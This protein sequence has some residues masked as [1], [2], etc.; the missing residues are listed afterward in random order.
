MTAGLERINAVRE[1]MQGAEGRGPDRVADLKR[2]ISENIRPGMTVHTMVTHA[3]P[4]GLVNEL[5]RQFWGKK[6][7]FSLVTLGA[8]NHA[9]V[10]LSGG[11]LDRIVT[12]YC[13]DIYPSPGPHPL[14]QQAYLQ[15]WPTIENWSLIS[16]VSR[17]MAGALGLEALPVRSLS[18]TSM[19]EENRGNYA[20]VPSPFG[21]PPLGLVKALR[22]DITLLHG[23]V[24][25]RAGNT[26]LSPP[27]AEGLWGALGAREGV[28]VSVEKIVDTDFIRAHA[29]LPVLPAARVRAVVE[30]PF[31]AHPG[32]FFGRPIRGCASYAEDYD[33]IVDF[34]NRSRR[35][36]AMQQWLDTYVLGVAD[37]QEYLRRVGASRLG[38]L[39]GRAHAD[40]WEGELAS[41]ACDVPSGPA[42]PFEAMVAEAARQL[43]SRIRE[44]GHRSILAGQ[45]LSNLAAWLA[46]YRLR[47]QDV[48]IDLVAEAGFYGYLPRPGNPFLFNFA[49]LPRCTMLTDSLHTLG[50][51]ICGSF[52][53]AIGSL[54]AGQVDRQGHINSTL[55]PGVAYLVGSGGAAD[56]MA[57]AEEV[58]LCV[59]LRPL[60][61]VEKVPYVMA[62]GGRVVRVVSERGVLAKEAGQDELVLTQVTATSDSEI[63]ERVREMRELVGWELKV[64]PRLELTPRPEPLDIEAVRLFDPR[65][66][67]LER[68]QEKE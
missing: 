31:G 21:G 13:G 53:R 59:P 12:S 32:G 67:F 16:L 60:R 56:V 39:V 43:V 47:R 50:T 63:E 25:D 38:D 46:A 5:A 3:M 4:Y 40:A 57:A 65:R 2:A 9:V 22:P 15:G 45:G 51:E 52:A 44:K 20:E 64:S 14:F 48:E 54:S 23:W 19:A 42:T 30:L 26:L 58:V 1:F 6:P 62:P 41:L 33:F 49:N 37:H 28:V 66:A 36:E 8:V 61:Y 27:L 7:G 34:R 29:H 17:L 24:A 35:P 11:L 10:L 55:V 18:R 68:K